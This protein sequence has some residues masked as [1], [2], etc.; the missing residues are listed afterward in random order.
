MLWRKKI[1]PIGPSPMRASLYASRHLPVGRALMWFVRAGLFVAVLAVLTGVGVVVL[2]R[3][4]GGDALLSP[5]SRALPIPAVR[6]NGQ[7]IPY[8][9]YAEMLDGWVF[10]YERQGV[11]EA[12]G[13]D[14]V[15]QRVL[16]RL[17]QD[18]LVMQMLKE[19][20]TTVSPEDERAL[21]ET[22]A[23]PYT[24][25]AMFAEAIR[26]QFGWDTEAFKAYVVEPLVRLR[27]A[28]EAVLE[29]D[30]VQADPRGVMEALYADVRIAPDR[31]E[32]MA[33]QASASFLAADGEEVGLRSIVE[34]PMG[35][36]AAL[37]AT[38]EG[39]ITDVIEMPDRFVLYLV[40]EREEEEDGEVQVEVRELSIEK[41][42]VHD[43]L[44]EW[45]AAATVRVYVK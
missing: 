19:M 24:G 5:L 44:R 13:K 3:L 10:L 6:V 34:Y 15:K 17:V 16:D 28:D 27:K 29:W 1:E 42:D 18:A 25:E 8:R 33:T 14:T 39:A 7:G 43:V 30:A 45:L 41:R 11:L 37:T 32:E 22:L 20:R 21:W 26:E 9:A 2:Y 38:P 36:R 40:V 35:V 23:R 12:V 31:F 4:P